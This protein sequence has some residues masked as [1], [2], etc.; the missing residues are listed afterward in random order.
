MP[1]L[2]ISPR[3][4]L[5]LIEI[6]NYIADDSADNADSFIDQLNEAMQ[7]LCHQPGMGRKREELAPQIRSFPYQR[8]V[9][10]YRQIQMHSRSSVSFTVH[11]TW[12]AVLSETSRALNRMAEIDHLNLFSYEL[13]HDQGCKYSSTAAQ[14]SL[15]RQLALR[16]ASARMARCLI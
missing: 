1:P 4:L 2:R 9:I 12:R 15:H 14:L 5:D 6:W 8:Y 3:A 13:P 11:A 16:T 7:K 10:F